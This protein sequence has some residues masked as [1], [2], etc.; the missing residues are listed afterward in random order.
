M[1]TI[2]L[3]FKDRWYWCSHCRRAAISCDHCGNSSCNGS[4]CDLCN[5]DFDEVIDITNKGLAPKKEELKVHYA[6]MDIIERR[7]FPYLDEHGLVYEESV[8]KDFDQKECLPFI[9]DDFDDMCDYI[10]KKSEGDKY[11]VTGSSFETY[12][13][14]YL[15]KGKEYVLEVMIGQGTARTLYTKSRYE[16]AVEN[17][18]CYKETGKWLE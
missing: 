14:P 12:A 8:T 1:D 2:S 17:L 10:W 7:I 4:G 9:K 6:E 13:V 15:Y 18:R 5:K 11:R 16:Q 3:K